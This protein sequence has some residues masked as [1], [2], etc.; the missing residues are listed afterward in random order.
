MES[1]VRWP[2]N[3]MSWNSFKSFIYLCVTLLTI[4]Q[5]FVILAELTINRIYIHTHIYIYIHIYIHI[6]IYT[7]THI[8]IY[9]YTYIH[10]HIYIYIC[11]CVCVYNFFVCFFCF[12]KNAC[13]FSGV[14]RCDKDSHQGVRSLWGANLRIKW[15]AVCQRAW[16]NGRV[17][18]PYVI[19]FIIPCL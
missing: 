10:I 3:N 18:G 11:V 8:Y 13:H 14:F 12:H 17:Q 4:K 19:F 5:I 15:G 16:A 7:Y 6:H 1:P 9:I 2:I